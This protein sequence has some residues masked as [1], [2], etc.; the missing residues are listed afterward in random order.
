MKFARS[1]GFSAVADRMEP[2]LLPGI[3][4][5][6][7]FALVTFDFIYELGRHSLEIPNRMCKYE[8]LTS[9]YFKS[10]RLTDGQTNTRDQ[11]YI[12]QETHQEMR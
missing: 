8:L 6:D 9:R 11:N 1:I 4:I 7:L 3:G 2:E 10:Y 5:F 12:K